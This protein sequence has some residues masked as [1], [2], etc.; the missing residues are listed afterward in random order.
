MTDFLLVHGARHG[1]WCWERTIA[2]LGRRGHRAVA[3][4][5]PIDDPQAGA[6]RYAA[7]AA[8]A[9]VRF[10][11]P[12]VAVGHSLGGLVIPMLPELLRIEELVFLCSPLPI[13][14]TSLSQQQERDPDIF[15][16]DSL[17]PD[18]LREGRRVER[19]PESAIAVFFHDC[20]DDV[21]RFAVAR[22]RPQA[23]RPMTEPSPV[24]SWPPAVRCRYVMCRDDRIMNPGWCRR[25][26][27][28]SLGV[29]PIELRGGHSPFLSRPAELVDA[30]LTI[31]APA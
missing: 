1:A 20:P 4:D 26:V 12:V 3:P 29:R 31:A 30:L 17:P 19:S 11:S 22:L 6:S 10:E 8:Q 15:F 23:T 16:R 28:R 27:P 13:P 2:E 5:L 9:A 21:A 24:S 14:G 18:M 25:E 7:V